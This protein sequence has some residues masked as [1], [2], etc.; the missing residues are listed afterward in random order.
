MDDNRNKPD[1]GV[2][3]RF[4]QEQFP[5]ALLKK[6]GFFKSEMKNDYEAQAKRVCQFFG[7]E[8]VYEYGAKEIR[9][10]ISYA[11]GQR[12][13]GEGFITVIPGTYD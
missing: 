13:E 7:Y 9:C 5:F 2:L 4:M 10:H 1:A 12:P 8:T 6:A 11:E 3:R